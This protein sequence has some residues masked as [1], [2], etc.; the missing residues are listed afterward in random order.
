MDKIIEILSS[1]IFI[2]FLKLVGFGLF[3]W[4][5]YNNNIKLAL[6]MVVIFN[7]DMLFNVKWNN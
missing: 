3:I 7:T 4:F 6:L 5:M 1:K 2:A